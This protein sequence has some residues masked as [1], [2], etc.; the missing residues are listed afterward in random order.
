M[1]NVQLT[2]YLLVNIEHFPPLIGKKAWCFLSHYVIFF[3]SMLEVL[4]NVIGQEK[5]KQKS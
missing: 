1:K 4:T 3:N 5:L 2:F